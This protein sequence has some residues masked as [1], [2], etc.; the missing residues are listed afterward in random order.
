MKGF[1]YIMTNKYNSVLYIGVTC[2]LKQRVS[3]H[4]IKKHP[5]S[6]TARYNICKLVY[7]ELCDTIGEAI[8]KSRSKL[9]LRI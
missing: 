4:I 2:D 1:V 9:I 7:Y 5:G 8:P 3:D 6:F